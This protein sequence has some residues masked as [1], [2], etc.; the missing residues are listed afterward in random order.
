MSDWLASRTPRPPEELSAKLKE[1]VGD[2]ECGAHELSLVLITK[3]K[4][5]LS[6]VGNDRSAAVDLLVA[7]ALI[8]YAMEAAADLD[9]VDS[10]ARYAMN[11]IASV[12]NS[13]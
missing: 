1:I 13:P 4:A 6:S 3:A 12:V 7:D 10:A 11:E 8:T 9:S 5:A 2:G